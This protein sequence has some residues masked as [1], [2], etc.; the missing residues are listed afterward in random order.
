MTIEQRKWRGGQYST[1]VLPFANKIALLGNS[2]MAQNLPVANAGQTFWTELTAFGAGLIAVPNA[3]NLVGGYKHLQYVSSGGTSGPVE[4]I[5]PAVV[6]GTVIDGSITWTAQARTDITAFGMGGWT[7]AQMLSGQRL[8]EVWMG[9]FS[10]RRSSYILSNLPAAMAANP[11][12]VYFSSLFEND[13]Q[14]TTPATILANWNNFVAQADY[15]RS[16]GRR[17]MLDTLLP[18][19]GLDASSAFTGYTAGAQT[20]AWN[21]LNDKIKEYARNR[22]DVILFDASSVF[23][24]PNPAN[25]VWPENATTYISQSGTGQQ[26]KKTDGIHPYISGAY[27]VGKALAAVLREH[28]PAANRFHRAKDTYE[29][30]VN[31][32][33]GGSAGTRGLGMTSGPVP[34]LMTMTAYGTVASAIASIVQRTDISGNFAQC[35]VVATADATLDYV[36]TGSTPAPASWYSVGAVVQ[37]F[38]EIKVLANPTLLKQVE[39]WVKTD[40][41]AANIWR[42]VTFL[43]SSQ[44]DWGQM[45]TEDT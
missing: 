25:P 5:W 34:S 27:L 30:A 26:L 18:N 4:P 21:W 12:V 37:A 19:G 39:L 31:P 29:L 22:P 23:T 6:G 8:D 42:G 36:Q 24:D 20:K 17:V 45:I 35:D 13:M 38:G 40:G 33:N 28:F 14:D 3:Y 7:F 10:G 16:L 41:A 44:Q 15:V 9:G 43:S 2:I 1:P 32:D 11:D